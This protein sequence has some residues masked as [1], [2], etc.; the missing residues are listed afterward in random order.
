MTRKKGTDNSDGQKERFTRASGK[1]DYNM[2]KEQ[3]SKEIRLRL[4][5]G[6][7]ERE[8]NGWM[9]HLLNKNDQILLLL[10]IFDVNKI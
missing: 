7:M 4:E 3:P 2:E 1:T 6:K 10:I 8:L 9:K 5:C